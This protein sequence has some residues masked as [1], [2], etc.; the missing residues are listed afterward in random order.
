MLNGTP[1]RPFDAA[2]LNKPAH[3]SLGEIATD[4]GAVGRVLV[5]V[6]GDAQSEQLARYTRQLADGLGT[7]WMAT[8]FPDKRSSIS[9]TQELERM[10]DVLQ[11]VEA[12]GGEVVRIPL[13][14]R[15]ADDLIKFAH[16]NNVAHI[17]IAKSERKRW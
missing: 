7:S 9:K 5:C 2:D 8:P 14:G 15:I 10:D 12:L 6:K 17:V 16:R 11:L 13:S 3:N 1:I 4:L